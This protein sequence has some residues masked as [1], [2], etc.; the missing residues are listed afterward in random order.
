MDIEVVLTP[1][2]LGKTSLVGKTVVVF[3][4]L[5]ATTTIIAAFAAGIRSVHAF[6]DLA[7]AKSA[8]AAQTPRPILCSEL[9]ALP[10]PGVDMGNS[11]GQFTAE[12]SGRDVFMATTNGT[13]ALNAARSA[14]TLFVGA[15]VNSAAAAKAAAATIQPVILLGSGTY[16][17][18]AMEDAIGAGA[19]CDHLLRSGKYCPANDAARMAHQLFLSCRNDLPRVLRDCQGGKNV[20]KAGLEPDID[21]AARLDVFDIA[22]VVNTQNLVI[23]RV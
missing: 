22:G 16:G 8:A 17:E 23:R 13:K 14:S 11:P 19:V 10:A 5:R 18:I 9:H 3:D 15:L 7:D 2:G 4:V 6:A 1:T 21:F 20:T 12:H